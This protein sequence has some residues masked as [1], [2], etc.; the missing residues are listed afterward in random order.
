[1]F[2]PGLRFAVVEIDYPGVYVEEFPSGVR[3]ITGV[4][5]SIAGFVGVVASERRRAVHVKSFADFA[6]AFGCA[7]P[8]F[9]LG[10]AVSQFFAN[11]GSEAWVVGVPQRVPLSEG[12]QDL[13]HADNLNLLCLPG[14]TEA[15][16][17]RAALAYADRRRAFVLIDSPGAD[18]DRTIALAESLAVSE[19]AN[20][21]MFFP[22]VHVDDAKG[23]L[24]TCPASGAVAGMYA[25]H[26]RALGVWKPAEGRNAGLPG[27]VAPAVE[28]G[29]AA[30]AKLS[31]VG[32]NSIRSFARAGVRV[33][34]SRTLEG[35]DEGTS[36]WKSI[37]VRRLALFIEESL[38]R[39]T[40]WAVF[41]PNDEPLWAKLRAQ[42]ALFLDA[43]FRAGALLGRTPHEAYFVRCGRDTMSQNDLDNGR[44]TLMIGIAP[45]RPAEFVEITIGQWMQKACT[46]SLGA[47]GSPAERL[48]L[49]H[50]P[51][52]AEG[53][54]LQVESD[55]G[56]TTWTEVTNFDDVNSSGRVY[57]LDRDAGELTFGDGEHGAGLPAGGANI[58]ATYRYG[59]S[60]KRADQSQ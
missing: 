2:Q 54:F 43:L 32:V 19:A 50:R 28:V 20:G 38:Y 41:E 7:C 40:R 57:T 14:E 5:T 17:L 46:Q 6:H 13:E 22:P 8:S 25:R 9:E 24:S 58:Q 16:V 11:G 31:A 29:E 56:W 30:I 10:A 60:R 52:A 51:V 1:L 23:A 34:G 15:E 27:V 53:V 36:E 49:R 35:G 26:D 44:L 48:C 21:A 45:S 47:T 4:A 12:L 18:V 3:P 59:I 33:W 39:G 55:D 37:P 42:T